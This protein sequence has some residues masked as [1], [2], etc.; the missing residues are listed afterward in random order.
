MRVFVTGATGFIGSAVVQELIGAGHTVTG[1]AR[2]DAA[3]RSLAAAGALA[4]RG[5]LDDLDSLRRGA[6][7][8]DGVIHLAFMHGLP[9]ASLG[10]RLRIL[11]GGLPGGIVSRFMAVTTGAD[12]AAIDAMGAALQNSGRP[13]VATFGTMG[14]VPSGRMTEDDAPDP[15]SPGAARAVT[16]S[17]VQAW[18]A[19]GVRAIIARLPPSVH[20]DGD[21]GL[22][23]QLIGIARKRG[24]A[25]YVGDGLNRWSAVHRNDAAKL[26]RLAL[27]NGVAGAR[28]HAVADE[29]VPFRDIAGVI[30]R[31]LG[32]PVVSAT[33]AEAAQQFSWFAPFVGADNP[34]TSRYTREQ[35]GWAPSGP[36]LIADIDRAGYFAA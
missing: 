31:R 29:G 35:L 17:A 24:R 12:R 13:L 26:F 21:T 32:V 28:Y 3:A 8:A 9:Q 16:E 14:L 1:L 33:P 23:P 22:V 25:A 6:A 11:L 5:S 4:H 36:G 7:A 18:A 15:R 10:G 19:R 30:G 20:G 2:T 27:E 34:A